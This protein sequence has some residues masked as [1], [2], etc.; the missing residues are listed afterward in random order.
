M[1]APPLFVL[2]KREQRVVAVIVL[3]LLFA[4]LTKHYRYA[5]THTASPVTTTAQPLVSPATSP[6]EEERES[7][8]E[9]P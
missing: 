6:P 3:V 1:K 9:S 2:T 4:A 5:R 7:P 8:D